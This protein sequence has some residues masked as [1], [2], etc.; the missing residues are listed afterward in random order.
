[1]TWTRSDHT[2][3]TRTDRL[4]LRF[5]LAR[6]LPFFILLISCPNACQLCT[7]PWT[8]ISSHELVEVSPT[9]YPLLR[10]RP[11]LRVLTPLP[12]SSPL[13][14]NLSQRRYNSFR[15]LT[16]SLTSVAGQAASTVQGATAN[17]DFNQTGKTF[18]K[19]FANLSQQVKER[20]GRALEDD[21]TELPQEYLDLETRVDG[22]RTAHQ[23]LLKVAGVY[24]SGAY[25][26]PVNLVENAQEL[27]GGVFRN[28]SGWAAAATKGTHLPQPAVPEKPVDLPKTLPH[29]LSRAS[30]TSAIE[31]GPGRLS[32]VLKTYA[33]A[34]DKVGSARLRQDET[35]QREFLGPWSATLSSGIAAAMKARGEV[36]NARLSLDATRATFKNATN[37]PRQEQARMEV[38]AAEEH[39]V[40]S[41]EEAI[42]L[43]RAVLENP[44]PIKNLASLI[45]AQREFYEAAAESLRSVEGEVEEKAVAAEGE[46][47][48]SRAQ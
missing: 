19:G 4:S 15:N 47:R 3:G 32:E 11:R 6:F 16:A 43:M 18:T 27:G 22:L 2:L 33:V 10:P 13:T 31:V 45:K 38:E 25:D 23:Q 48:K 9:P 44:E 34:Q 36:K 8:L 42:N 14:P 40:T 12:S 30:S 35:I 26:Y 28:V 41:T 1:M 21:V 20:T 17:V 7:L 39:L 46:Y 5:I 24:K 37:G 29:A